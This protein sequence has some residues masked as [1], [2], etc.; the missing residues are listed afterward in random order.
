M[1]KHSWIWWVAEIVVDTI[2]LMVMMAIAI[3]ILLPIVDSYIDDSVFAPICILGYMLYFSIAYFANELANG[4]K[5]Y[6]IK[7]LEHKFDK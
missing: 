5:E 3:F 6:L 2:L 7:F 1:R 4:A